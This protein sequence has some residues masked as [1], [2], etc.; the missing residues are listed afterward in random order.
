MSG[1][2]VA[3]WLPQMVILLDVGHRG[4]GL[5]GQLRDGPVVVEPGQRRE[6][7]DGDVRGVA[8][9]DQGVGVRR[10]A[11][12]PDPDVVRRVVVEG[13]A[14]GGED[15]AVGLEQVAALHALGARTSADQQ[16]QVDPVEDLGRVVPDLDLGQV[17]EGAVVQLHHHALERRQRRGDL[18]QAQLDR[19]VLAEQVAGGDPEEQAVADLAGGAGDGDL[20]GRGAHG[21]VPS[22]AVVLG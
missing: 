8:H 7:L 1:Y 4:P 13:L 17:R 19:G 2:W 15:R 21:G 16:G 10:V 3:E 12:H 6:P 20:D 22:G 14:L 18:Q 9:R 11:G 5:G